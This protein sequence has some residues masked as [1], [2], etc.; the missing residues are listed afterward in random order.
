[1]TIAVDLGRKATKQTKNNKKYFSYFSTETYIVVTQKIRLNMLK[2]K[3]KKISTILHSKT[4]FIKTCRYDTYTLVQICKH[5]ECISMIT[6]M[7]LFK[8]NMFDFV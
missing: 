1:M 6:F 2:L 8:H 4:L 5:F 3:G 7:H